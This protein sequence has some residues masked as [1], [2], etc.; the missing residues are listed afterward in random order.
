MSNPNKRSFLLALIAALAVA[1]F[2]STDAVAA[3]KGVRTKITSAFATRLIYIGSARTFGCHVPAGGSGMTGR[4]ERRKG[5]KTRFFVR[6]S[7]SADQRSIASKIKVLS[8]RIKRA[9]K[10]LR[11]RLNKTRTG[12]IKLSADLRTGSRQC[13][14]YNQSNCVQVIANKT[15]FAPNQ[16][17]VATPTPAPQS[18]RTPVPALVSVSSPGQFV[19]AVVN[20]NSP[21]TTVSLSSDLDL[22]GIV[23]PRIPE[24]AGVLAGNG[25][26]IRNLARSVDISGGGRQN[27]GLFDTVSGTVKDL[28]VENL[29]LTVTCS[30]NAAF[31]SGYAFIGGIAGSTS[32]GSNISNVSVSGVIDGYGIVGGIVGLNSGTLTNVTNF[33]QIL[34]TLRSGESLCGGPRAG[35][36]GF[37]DRGTISNATNFGTVNAD[38][39]SRPGGHTSAG[40]IVANY[41]EDQGQGSAVVSDARNFGQI[42]AQGGFAGG[43]VGSAATNKPL[44]LE[45]RRVA[46]HAAI[47]ADRVG[48]IVGWVLFENANARIS[49]LESASKGAINGSAMAGGIVGELNLG[50][51]RGGSRALIENSSVSAAVTSLNFAGGTV[52]YYSGWS[53]APASRLTVRTAVIQFPITGAAGSSGGIVGQI[54]TQ[55]NSDATLI[56]EGQ[57]N[58]FDADVNAA[59][60]LNSLLG[61]ALSTSAL[62]QGL[63][64][65]STIWSEISGQYPVIK[66][67]Q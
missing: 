8:N 61:T 22:T 37:M 28:I 32:S 49:I 33:A 48:G 21:Q 12:L 44:S 23:L 7:L 11:A 6:S 53:N 4:I 10:S 57:T 47:N 20:N 55:P 25:Y 24:F 51:N 5:E 13:R 50:Q 17:G 39:C 41:G 45:L 26:T 1:G 52:G 14:L 54:G 59:S 46:N 29:S 15:C 66:F 9:P 19:N 60:G 64:L 42:K 40:G 65:N 31:C 67:A 2:T 36:A 34:G 27:V 58:F 3:P 43:I 16:N 35:I 38:N 62:Q 18:T 30:G 63:G 56:S